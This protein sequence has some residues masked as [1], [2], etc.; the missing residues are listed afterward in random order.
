MDTFLTQW[1]ILVFN[2]A[3]T[4]RKFSRE[5][6]AELVKLVVASG[7]SVA[8]VAKAHEI[9]DSVVATWV[10]QARIDA[11]EGPAGALTTQ[12]RAELAA[13]RKECREL[14]MERDFLKKCS[15]WFARQTG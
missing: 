3:R 9:S 15:A 8:E 7:Q 1:R 14:R 12:E 2:M 11:G 10:R 6:K 4:R 13:L 5:F